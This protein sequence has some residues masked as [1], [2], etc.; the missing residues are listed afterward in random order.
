M[1]GLLETELEEHTNDIKRQQRFS[2]A[3]KHYIKYKY[4]LC[5]RRGNYYDLTAIFLQLFYKNLRRLNQ[6]TNNEYIN[7]YT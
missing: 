6:L 1:V 2:L 3:T 7:I 5:Q 4:Y